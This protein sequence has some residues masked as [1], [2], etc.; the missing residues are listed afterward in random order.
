MLTAPKI[1]TTGSTDVQIPTSTK[2]P[3]H[4]TSAGSTSSVN[5]IS[6]SRITCDVSKVNFCDTDDSNHADKANTITSVS[7]EPSGECGVNG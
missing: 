5:R 1:P 2:S 7:D 4:L 6:V 3:N